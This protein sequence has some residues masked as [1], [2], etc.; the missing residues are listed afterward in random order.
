MKYVVLYAVVVYLH[1]QKFALEHENFSVVNLENNRIKFLTQ[2]YAI[3]RVYG[4]A[5]IFLKKT[6]QLMM[7]VF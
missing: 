6:Y 7:S 2:M 5:E 4:F 1:L 3:N